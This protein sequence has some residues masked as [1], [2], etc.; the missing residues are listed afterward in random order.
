MSR[1]QVKRSAKTVLLEA[2][3]EEISDLCLHAFRGGKQ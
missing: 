3:I 2:Q 1:I